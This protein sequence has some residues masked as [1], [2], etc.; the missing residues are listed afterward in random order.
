MDKSDAP[1]TSPGTQSASAPADPYIG[2]LIQQRFRIESWIGS[3]GMSTV[4]KAKD[5]S[6]GRDVAIKVMIPKLNASQSTLFRFQKEGQAL[7]RLNHDNIVRVFEFGII[8]DTTQF[9]VMEYISGV[10]L[11]ELLQNQGTL[12]IARTIKVVSQIC[13]AL[14][15][16]HTENIVHRDL[17]PSNVVFTS[18]DANEER[19]KIIDF[20]I[21]KLL[22][23]T[24]MQHLTSTGEVF[25]SPLYMSPEQCY[26]LQVDKRSDIYSLGCIM[27]E[28]LTGMPPFVGES[29]LATLM[30]HQQEKPLSLREA[31]LGT[32]FPA[33]LE[34][35]VARMLEKR[36]EDRYQLAE[37]LQLD[38]DR[39]K[40]IDWS[41]QASTGNLERVYSA[42]QLSTLL[43][44][45]V[46][47][48]AMPSEDTSIQSKRRQMMIG[49]LVGLCIVAPIVTIIV[50]NLISAEDHQH[51]LANQ[52]AIEASHAREISLLLQ[53]KDVVNKVLDNNTLS[54]AIGDASPYS[55]DSSSREVDNKND[56]TRL[57]T[58]KDL[59][60][61]NLANTDVTDKQLMSIIHLPLRYLD[62]DGCKSVTDEGFKAV[63]HMPSLMVFRFGSVPVKLAE[64]AH[65]NPNIIDLRMETAMFTDEMTPELL[66]L[67][68]L[69]R[70]DLRGNYLTD[71]SLKTLRLMKNLDSLDVRGNSQLTWKAIGELT[72]DMPNC[73]VYM[74][75]NVDDKHPGRQGSPN[76]FFRAR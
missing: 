15:H 68:K 11:S 34:Q 12:S 1:E 53:G 52:R 70:L 14:A 42:K 48:T 56:W 39:L 67:R 49:I 75:P 29:S 59:V 36:P 35:I 28:C 13:S 50:S 57:M 47:R 18:L 9:M 64:V 4:Y 40:D 30:K 19:V 37:E 62:L 2:R 60:C 5:L 63:E 17:K 74:N 3:G 33:V 61:L 72:H 24:S 46:V 73:V 8:E 45:Q 44:L 51:Q 66:R 10:P 31:T 21:A 54:V 27:Y 69:R 22:S 16:A 23:D 38:L 55:I 41:D 26:G 43:P 25:G 76:A 6:L 20:G 32:V 58:R 71:K 7:S 65:I